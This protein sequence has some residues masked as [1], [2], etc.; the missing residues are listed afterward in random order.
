MGRLQV[1]AGTYPW[2]RGC[3]SWGGI[4]AWS[5]SLG[6]QA[7]LKAELGQNPGR[8]RGPETQKR[9]LGPEVRPQEVRQG[10]G[11]TRNSDVKPPDALMCGAGP[12]PWARLPA[13]QKEHYLGPR[14]QQ[15]VRWEGGKTAASEQPGRAGSDPFCRGWS[16]NDNPK[17]AWLLLRALTPISSFIYRL[18][19]TLDKGIL[20]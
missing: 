8:C 14:L 12:Q 6:G 18:W 15:A 9:S 20:L 11:S 13:F 19:A 10:T 5:M 7:P 2:L 1:E 17:L 3:R 16:T 4:A